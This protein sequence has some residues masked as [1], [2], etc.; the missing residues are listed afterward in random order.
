MDILT[1]LMA[2]LDAIFAILFALHGVA[3]MIVNLTPT[4]ADNAALA[5]VYSVVEV[6][7]GLV[8][9]KSKDPGAD[10]VTV[11]LRDPRQPGQ[12]PD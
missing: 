11:K 9:S 8:S 3:L 6:L 12:S 1:W 4:P 5:K 2:N 10:K 7:A